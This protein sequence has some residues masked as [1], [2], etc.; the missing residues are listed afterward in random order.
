MSVLRSVSTASDPAVALFRR[1]RP[2]CL[3]RST[4]CLVYDPECFC[5][6]YDC[7]FP[8]LTDDRPNAVIDGD[9]APMMNE[10][11]GNG[12]PISAFG[13]QRVIGHN[14]SDANFDG[15]SAVLP[16]RD[17]IMWTDAAASP[18]EK[19]ALNQRYRYMSPSEDAVE[20]RKR[21][22]AADFL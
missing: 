5:E 2:I 16:S 19:R 3:Y 17:G 20:A 15:A 12:L 18:A 8:E 4:V 6:S 21:K 13:G 14:A 10:P 22:A 11:V 1:F 7:Q 9:L